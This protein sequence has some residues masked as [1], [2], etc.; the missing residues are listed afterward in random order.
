MVEDVRSEIIS[1]GTELLLGEI[2]DTNAA[3]LG[4]RL[5][6]LG[7]D[8]YH[9]QTV[10]DNQVRLV[11]ALQLALSRSDLVLVSGRPTTMDD[12]TREA[13]P[14]CKLP[15]LDE[16]AVRHLEAYFSRI[17]RAATDNNRRRAYRPDGAISIANRRALPVFWPAI[18]GGPM[19]ACRGAPGT[20]D[21]VRRKVVP[22]LFASTG[23]KRVIKSR[24]LLLTG[25]GESTSCHR[26]YIKE[27]TNPTIASWD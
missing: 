6:E 12:N 27:Q 11:A 4:R 23:D 24:M 21:H 5:A 22:R 26:R 10:G 8:V 9:R 14:R 1:F 20:G 7:V 2:V 13:L 25:L 16:A 18:K 19:S 3:F 17:G 15:R